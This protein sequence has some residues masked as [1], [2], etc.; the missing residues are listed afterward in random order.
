MFEESAIERFGHAIMLRHV[1][2]CKSTLGTFISKKVGEIMA[3]KLTAA[4]QPKTFDVRAMLSLHPGRK[5]LVSTKSLVLSSEN[6]KPSEAREVVSECD[7]VFATSKAEYRRWSPDIRVHLSTES[8]GRWSL[9]LLPNRLAG[10]L[11]IFTQVTDKR[12]EVVY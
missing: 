12:W 9:A 3:S 11:S 4:I 10:R 6:L 1:V 8:V 7:I 5:R 2:S